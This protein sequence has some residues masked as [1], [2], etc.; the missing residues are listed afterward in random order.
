MLAKEFLTLGGLRIAFRRWGDPQAPAIVLLMGLGMS[1]DAWP[2]TMIDGLVQEGFQVIT[3]DN[4]DSGASDR[5]ASWRV[6]RSEL[7]WSILRFLMRR[8]VSGDYAL[9]DMAMDV[10]HLLDALGI[11]RAHIAG[12]S[13]GGM[14]AQT[15]AY[16]CP[17]RV[18]TMTS[19]SSAV[20]NP[21]TGLGSL[22]A[23]SAVLKAEDSA[24]P[25]AQRRHVAHILTA[26]SGP[27]YKPTKAE[28]ETALARTADIGRDPDAVMRQ[29]MALLAS[30]DRS[31]QVRQI[32]VPALVIHGTADPLLPFA[33]GEET[34][35]LIS[36]SQFLPVEGLGHAVPL[37]LVPLYVRAI[38]SICHAHPA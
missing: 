27:M 1:M 16:H 15:L 14:I 4:R 31:D 33:A 26:L 5:A 20:G 22:R 8:R 2:Q 19:M 24:D 11:R 7:V 34:A 37:V 38:A 25:E 9:E 13:L 30:G 21:R 10:E 32:R 29:V 23:I 35:R 12:V 36:G 17:N 3:P 28:I 18:A 6:T